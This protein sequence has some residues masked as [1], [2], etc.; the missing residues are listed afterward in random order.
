MFKSNLLSLLFISLL[1]ITVFT[2]CDNDDDD[3]VPE[4][5]IS[6]IVAEDANFSILADALAR[7]NLTATLESDGPFTVFAPNDDAF[8]NAG[9][10]IDALTDAELAEVLL[11]HVFG[12]QILRSTDIPDGLVYL[13]TAA[14]TGPNTAPLTL[15]LEKS[16]NDVI[17][18]SDVQVTAPDIEAGNGIIH[19]IDG[20]LIP[21][22]LVGH[23]TANPNFSELA[24]A[25]GVASGDLGSVLS[26]TGPFTVLAPQDAAF[27]QVQNIVM[28]FTP[29]QFEKLLT[30]HVISGNVRF[31]DLTAGVVPTVNGEE[32]VVNDPV[33][34]LELTDAQGNIVNILFTD[35]QA[36][37]G[38]IHIVN[39]VLLPANL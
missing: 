27:A 3:A 5:T 34:L 22:D 33:S 29:E 16:F 28:D 36:T 20:V 24:N 30:Y 14:N 1:S 2:S 13:S 9:I 35:V 7:V 25:I 32:I 26:G 31:Q 23:V 4:R 19:V 12:G 11:Y 38:V 17:L 37:N 15:L 6:E 21:L 39:E 8:Q 10:D 18:N